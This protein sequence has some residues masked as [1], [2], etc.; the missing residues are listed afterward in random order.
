MSGP[1]DDDS[2]SDINLK[3]NIHPKARTTPMIRAEI[4]AFLDRYLCCHGIL[5]LADLYP[6]VEGEKPAKKTFKDYDPG[7]MHACGHHMPAPDAAE[8]LSSTGDCH[9]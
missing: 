4:Q 1:T 2:D 7:F 5:R 6:E 9:R 3:A 8:Q